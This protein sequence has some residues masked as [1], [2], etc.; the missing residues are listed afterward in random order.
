MVTKNF[1]APRP[2]P[3]AAPQPQ[4]EPEPPPESKPEPKGDREPPAHVCRFGRIK[5][6]CW[7]N[8]REDGVWYSVTVTRSYKVGDEW[9]QAASFGKDD[10]LVVGEV[11]RQA[12]LWIAQ[13]TGPR[14]AAEPEAA[15]EDIPF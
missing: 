12:F 6:A 14:P 1:A 15:E 11:C 4:P 3:K 9:R 7:R 13:Q 2:A 8:H 5:A 10:L